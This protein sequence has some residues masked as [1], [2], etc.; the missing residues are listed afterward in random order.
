M[1]G[2]RLSARLR[3]LWLFLAIL[4]TEVCS[5]LANGSD[6][7]VVSSFVPAGAPAPAECDTEV[8]IFMHALQ[9]GPQPS[10]WH[11]VVVCDVAG[12]QRFLQL[13]GRPEESQILASTDLTART[14][15]LR[16][17]KLLN[18]IEFGANPEDI[19]GHELAHIQLHSADEF[20]AERLR[21]GWSRLNPRR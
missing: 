6:V 9:A 20:D 1:Q 11:W 4:C 17:D 7:R 14:T 13:S 12:W 2:F 15:Y 10:T 18:T 3:G 8:E 21:Q 19:V 5:L 16:G